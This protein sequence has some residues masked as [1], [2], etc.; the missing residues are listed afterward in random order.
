MLLVVVV[1]VEGSGVKGVA[2]VVGVVAR[3][4]LMM[5]GVQLQVVFD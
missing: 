4:W 2:A 5:E 3:V 1:V